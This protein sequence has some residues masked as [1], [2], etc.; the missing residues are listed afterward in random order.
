MPKRHTTDCEHSRDLNFAFER[1]DGSNALERHN[2]RGHF[3]G[4]SS[5]ATH[6]LATKRNLVNAPQDLPLE[7]LA[8]LGCGIEM[9]AGTV[10]NSMKVPKGVSA[11][12]LG[13]VQLAL[14]RAWRSASSA[15]VR[16]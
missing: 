15:P 13:R 5:F 1:L 4:Q 3:F 7:M 2:V 12:Y 16:L 6:T 11:P 14:P 8:P 9:R 10:M